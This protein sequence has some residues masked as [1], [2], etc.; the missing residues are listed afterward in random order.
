[1]STGIRM[2]DYG[3]YFG[4]TY[5]SSASLNL[6]RMKVNADY[7]YRALGLDDGWTVNAVAGFLGNV[8]H[9]STINPGRWQSDDV[10]NTSNGYGL[11]Q[12]TPATKYINWL[13]LG[14]DPS[15]M[16]N[17][18][19]RIRYELAHPSVQW[20]K[21]NAYPL[22]F[23]QFTQSTETPEY[24]ASCWLKN[25]ERAGV[26]AEAKRRKY[27]RFWYEYLGGITP[28]TP[29][30]KSKRTGFKWVLYARKFRTRN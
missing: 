21:T 18:L 30:E 15:T 13:F 7:I 14:S 9:E 23:K 27:A 29:T 17:N 11:V 19:K 26:A 5:N 2:G 20:I 8:Q 12:W 4:S 25:Y 10:G 28:P 3:S 6:D 22:S 24:L 16:D 1:M